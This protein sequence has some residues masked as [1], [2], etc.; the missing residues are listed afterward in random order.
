MHDKQSKNDVDST[1]EDQIVPKRKLYPDNIYFPQDLPADWL[2]VVDAT[3]EKTIVT[4]CTDAQKM[5][6]SINVDSSLAESTVQRKK[7]YPDNIYFPQDLPPESPL[8]IDS[9]N[10]KTI[11]TESADA[12]KM[13]NPT[14]VD[15][16][17]TESTVP[18]RKLYPDNIYF[19]QDL[20]A[21]WPSVVDATNEKI[22]VTESAVAQKM[23]DPINMDSTQTESKVQR[24]KCYPDNIYFPQDLPAE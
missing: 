22:I 19:P 13:L 12:Q 17:A 7:C 2:W 20:P 15:S 6:D 8:A 3:D 4:G 21:D 1:N 24:K 14:N 10:E 11:V 5:L 18:K 9:T 16:T 23:L